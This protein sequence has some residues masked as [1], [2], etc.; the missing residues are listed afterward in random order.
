MEFAQLAQLNA[1]NSLARQ[2]HAGSSRFD[3][4]TF[5][6]FAENELKQ[7]V[8]KVY[9]RRYRELDALEFVPAA[10]GI[11]PGAMAWAYDSFDMR[12]QPQWMGAGATDMPRADVAKARFSFPVRSYSLGYGWTIEELMAARFTGQALDVKKANAT[13]RGMAE[14]EHNT[15]LSGYPS[16]NIP[17]FLTNPATPR[18]IVPTGNWASGASA[19]QVLGDMNAVVD[20]V[21]VNSARVHQPDTLA[22][23]ID[24]FRI[25]QNLRIPNTGI[26]VRTYFL[27]NNAF[28]KEIRP[29]FELQSAGPGGTA[30]MIAYQKDPM[31]C[32][33]VIPL[34]FTQLDPQV[35][36]LEVFVPTWQRHGG[37]VFYYPMSAAFGDG[38]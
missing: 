28:I 6:I 16:L 11:N 30:T 25:I 17:G 7:V 22:M 23:P 32:E 9:D 31:N 15:I 4:F 35:R 5:S 21:W 33:A 38:I 1:Y 20:S 13:R 27:E 36:G 3:D 14:M 2:R 26:S 29:M 18:V 8:P 10:T 24:K 19:D 12:G 37:A 34:P